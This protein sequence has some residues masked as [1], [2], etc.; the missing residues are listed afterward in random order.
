MSHSATPLPLNPA[1]QAELESLGHF[2]YL[3]NPGNMGD[4]L[5]AVA[6][7][8]VFDRLKLSYEMYDENKTYPAGYCLVYG[9]GGV[10]VPECGQLDNMTALFSAP[11]IGRCVILPHSI[12]GCDKLLATLD[13]RFTVFCREQKSYDYCTASGS[14]ARFHLSDDM[15]CYMDVDAYLSPEQAQ[16]NLPQPNPLL[17]LLALSVLPRRCRT[18]ILCRCYRKTIAR[19]N[20]HLKRRATLLPDGRK[21][22]FAMRCDAE[23]AGSVLPPECR[24]LPN[25]DISRYGG[26]MLR[27]P[28]FNDLLVTQLIT[29]IEPFDIIVTDR[30]HVSSAVMW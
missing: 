28:A 15:A 5:I 25:V 6:T 30:L 23:S 1:L 16:R 12:R 18:S 3:P 14:R 26:G 29:A 11:G 27:W 13:E 10:M 20:R 7:M 24:G 21:L 22:L 4:A 17:R 9:G 8:Q 19:L 2:V